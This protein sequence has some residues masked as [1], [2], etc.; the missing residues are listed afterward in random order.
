[1][2]RGGRDEWGLP[3]SRRRIT[4]AVKKKKKNRRSPEIVETINTY[5][6]KVEF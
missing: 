4:L 6:S 2:G 5:K 3:N 1:M